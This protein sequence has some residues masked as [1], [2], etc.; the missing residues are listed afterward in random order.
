MKVAHLSHGLQHL[1]RIR[2]VS[3]VRDITHDALKQ[4]FVVLDSE[5][6][7]HFLRE[8][9][10]YK[11]CRRAPTPM[12]G[13]LYASE[14]DQFVA[15]TE[16]G[17]QVLDSSFHLVSQVPSA[18]PIRC[19]L[20]SELLNRVV[21]AGDRNVTI[22]GFRYG[23]RSLQCRLSLSEGLGPS[24]VFSRLAL[25][26]SGKSPQRCFASCGTGV[27]VFDVAQGKLLSFRKELHSR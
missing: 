14:V 6:L 1:A 17:L 21:T 26:A 20:Y 7:L 3:P 9:G 8:D 19:G 10:T 22:W 16:G 11:N 18:V 24:D 27:A 4:Q 15:W 12:E 5:N 25:D 13:L 2:L 23:A